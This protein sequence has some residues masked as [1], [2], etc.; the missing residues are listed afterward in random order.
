M[1]KTGKIGGV[2][3]LEGLPAVVAITGSFRICA[4]QVRPDVEVNIVYIKDIEDAAAG[5]EAAF[6]LIAGGADVDHR[7]PQRRARP[8]SSRPPRRRAS[9]SPAAPSA[10]PPSRPTWC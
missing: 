5:K 3:A 8:A 10:I 2:Q 7:T 9:T 6:S 4:K 1:S